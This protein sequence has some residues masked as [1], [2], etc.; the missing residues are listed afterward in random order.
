MISAYYRLPNVQTASQAT[1]L[2]EHNAAT[3]RLRSG[4]LQQPPHSC[5]LLDETMESIAPPVAAHEALL[6]R[7]LRAL[8]AFVRDG[9]VECNYSFQQVRLPVSGSVT[10][11]STGASRFVDACHVSLRLAADADA[12][13]G[14]RAGQVVAAARKSAPLQSMRAYL[15]T[16]WE[17]W[18]SIRYDAGPQEK[19]SVSS[20]SVPPWLGQRLVERAK[21]LCAG[22][23]LQGAAEPDSARAFDTVAMLLNALAVSKGKVTVGEAEWT[24]LEA[25]CARVAARHIAEADSRQ[26]DTVSDVTD[27][28]EV[29][30]ARA[31]KVDDADEAF[32]AALLHAVHAPES[33]ARQE[34]ELEIVDDGDEQGSQPIAGS[35]GQTRC[36]AVQD[37]A[38]VG[39]GESSRGQAMLEQL[40]SMGQL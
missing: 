22:L 31:E 1:L 20:G 13:S 40:R 9:V 35:A 18:G 17:S 2:P 14:Q 7:Q 5:L 12:D 10:A 32:R 11:V 23:R 29:G 8:D 30:N 34:M 6:A 15:A 21:T 28:A 39:A 27:A 4:T 26:D 3:N 24:D 25:L 36:A 37:G 16:A 33:I 19:G 38:C